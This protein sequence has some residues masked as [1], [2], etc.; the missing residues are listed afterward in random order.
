[1]YSFRCTH[2]KPLQESQF[3]FLCRFI[4]YFNSEPIGG[5]KPQFNSKSATSSFETKSGTRFAFLCPA[6]AHPLPSYRFAVSFLTNLLRF[7]P[8]PI[9]GKLILLWG[10]SLLLEGYY[11][12]SR[13]VQQF[14]FIILFPAFSRSMPSKISCN[15]YLLH[16]TFVQ[17]LLVA[18]VQNFQQLKN[19]LLTR[20]ALGQIWR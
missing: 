17:N 9:S 8:R 3:Y 6:Q 18:Q 19:Q 11:G 13:I 2:L 20:K 15:H 16:T 1:M 10:T 5:A 4:L 7:Q 14:G 12:H